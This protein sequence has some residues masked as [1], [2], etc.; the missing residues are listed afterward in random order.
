MLPGILA[1]VAESS[2]TGTGV[3]GPLAR[4]GTAREDEEQTASGG[5]GTYSWVRHSDSAIVGTG[6]SYT[7]TASDVGEQIDLQDGVST[8]VGTE[9]GSSAL[10][11]FSAAD[12]ASGE[13]PNR[14]T[15]TEAVK[16]DAGGAPAAGTDTLGPYLDFTSANG[17]QCDSGELTGYSGDD[18]TIYCLADNTAGMATGFPGEIAQTGDRLAIRRHNNGTRSLLD[19]SYHVFSPWVSDACELEVFVCNG[20][21][22]LHNMYTYYDGQRAADSDVAYVSRVF[23]GTASFGFG[24]LNTGTSPHEGKVRFFAVYPS[25]HDATKRAEVRAA[26]KRVWAHVDQ[27]ATEMRG[28][29][30]LVDAEH[31]VD[32][33]DGSDTYVVT[34]TDRS[35]H[36]NDLTNADTAEQALIVTDPGSRW[37][38]RKVFVSDG[39]DDVLLGSSVDMGGAT[40]EITMGKVFEYAAF[41][42]S[43]RGFVYNDGTG[44]PRFFESGGSGNLALSTATD[45][46]IAA[47]SPGLDAP[48]S[49]LMSFSSAETFLRGYNGGRL[50]Q[51]DNPATTRTIADSGDVGLFAYSNGGVPGDYRVAEAFI[52]NVALTPT[53]ALVVACRHNAEYGVPLSA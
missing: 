30:L 19:D 39:V 46:V 10:G 50:Q 13:I 29:R 15:M 48:L 27:T 37:N 7:Y 47:L 35:P 8:V 18:F 34:A 4:S 33:V 40:G 24:G 42:S 38:G 21:T 53:E 2:K 26:L 16:D 44:Y 12:Y 3:A 41:T 49:V 20:T 23:D 32:R 6:S 36:G 31:T 9:V 1:G 25:V 51:E 5:S 45:A 14:G 17:L 43:A 11:W 52:C 22:S 28:L